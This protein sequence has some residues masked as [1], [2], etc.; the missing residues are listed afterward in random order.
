MKSCKCCKRNKESTGLFGDTTKEMEAIFY[1]HNGLSLAAIVDAKGVIIS[2]MANYCDNTVIA[3]E[4]KSPK[5][6][7]IRAITEAIALKRQSNECAKI[8]GFEYSSCFF[9]KRATSTLI[10]YEFVPNVELVL[11][12]EMDTLDSL[13]F[14]PNKY[15]TT[16]ESTLVALIKKFADKPK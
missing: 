5:E 12:F 2:Y 16:N 15:I 1:S 14:N 7:T 10:I 9:L 13:F 3:K 8:M 6:K 11:I 4:E